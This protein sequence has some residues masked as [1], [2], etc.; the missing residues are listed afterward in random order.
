MAV[1]AKNKIVTP[2]DPP[3]TADRPE[4]DRAAARALL[5]EEAV[6]LLTISGPGGVGKTRSAL[7]IAK[8]VA[9]HFADGVAWL[10]LAPLRDPAL[11]PATAAAAWGLMLA[12][13]Y[14]FGDQLERHM[15]ARQ[16]L[17]L[18]DNCE[19]V[20]SAVSACWLPCWPL[21]GGPGP[22][23]Q[24]RPAPHPGRAGASRAPLSLPPAGKPSTAVIAQSEAVRLFVERARAVDPAF[25]L[26]DADAPAVSAICRHLDGLPLAIELA[27]ARVTVF[28]PAAC[29][30]NCRSGVGRRAKGRA[31]CR[32]ASGR[33]R[34]HRLELR[35][36]LPGRTV[37]PTRTCCFCRRVHD[38]RCGGNG[39]GRVS[40]GQD[41]G[42]AFSAG[43]AKPRAPDGTHRRAALYP[44]RDGSRVRPGA[45]SG[46]R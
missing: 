13:I 45:A 24:P 46:T 7:E 36:A 26:V 4:T 3:H 42:S 44:A 37:A 10:D 11:V 5:L 39:R 28:S 19:H 6:P 33:S 18:I 38:R 15:R 14:R 34:H 27:A 17:L 29:W 20:L 1:G 32:F 30:P 43:R 22:G 35:L 21:P 16:Q 25:I 23:H 31:T 41:A 40:P 12:A 2:T 8:D 9:E